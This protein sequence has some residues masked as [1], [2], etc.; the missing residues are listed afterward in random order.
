VLLNTND[1]CRVLADMTIGIFHKS[2]LQN[3]RKFMFKKEITCNIK[4]LKSHILKYIH[5]IEE[6]YTY[7]SNIRKKK[8]NNYIA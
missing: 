8:E 1:L 4:W 7:I 2:L 3:C 6:Q 5:K